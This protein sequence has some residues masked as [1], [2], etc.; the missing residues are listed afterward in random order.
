M[1][2]YNVIIAAKE[3]IIKLKIIFAFLLILCL[4]LSG[5]KTKIS[6][7]EITNISDIIS[8]ET[9]L[10]SAAP[11]TIQWYLDMQTSWA[12]DTLPVPEEL[13][14]Y[15]VK[16]PLKFTATVDNI[17]YTVDFFQE[18]YPLGGF[19]QIR[20]T[21][22]NSTGS[23]IT[24]QGDSAYGIGIFYKNDGSGQN[25]SMS[26][27]NLEQSAYFTTQVVKY[28]TIKSGETSVYERMARADP[29]FFKPGGS[30]SF[31]FGICS[32]IIEIPVEVVK[33]N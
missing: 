8:S 14:G 33:L 17:E 22:L 21:A 20:L 28:E 13:S 26:A 16:V 27:V 23:D 5:C 32:N 1:I 12:L 4:L 7:A 18:Y 3:K 6:Q 31:F 29:D 9:I 2:N 30:Y 19:I 25:L 10:T 11:E 24:Y 15:A